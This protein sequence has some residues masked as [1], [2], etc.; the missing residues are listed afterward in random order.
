MLIAVVLLF[1]A[2]V[3][4]LHTRR[5][6]IEANHIEL[7]PADGSATA[8]SASP[9]DFGGADL[10]G[11]QAPAFTLTDTDGKKVSLSDLKGHPVIVN[12]W[13]TWCGPCKLE[14]PWFEEFA[15]KYKPQ[16][17][18]VLGLS[19]DDGI[20]PEEVAHAAKRIG[21]SYP[22]LMPDRKDLVSKAYGGVEYLPETFYVNRGG[23][24]VSVN[25]GVP[26]RDQMEAEIQSIV[27]TAGQ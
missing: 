19:Q 27:G 7:Q 1:W 24:V 22:V 17:L 10:R 13:A 11:K 16:G 26:S 9:P 14:M 6:T 25:A 3:H 21:V 12:F 18:I 8:D 20:S 23:T 2:G 15:N 5:A 4:N